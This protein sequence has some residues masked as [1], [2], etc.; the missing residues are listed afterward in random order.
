[1]ANK[2]GK[3]YIYL[4]WKDP[5]SREQILIGQLSKNGQYEFQYDFDIEK[6]LKKGFELLIAFDDINHKYTSDRLFPTFSSRIPDRRR[7]DI[8]LILNRYGLEQY[9]EYELLKKSGGRLPIDDL[10]FIDPILEDKEN[11]IIR[12]FYLAGPR[13]Y[14][15]CDSNDCSRSLNLSNEEELTLQCQPDNMYDKYAIKVL[16]KTKE[17]IGYI[18]RYYNKELI[19]LIEDGYNYTLKVSEYNRENNCNECLRVCLELKL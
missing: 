14:L 15:G 2:N 17:L 18:P 7:K 3:D 5:K 6:A 9:D 1:M 8:A 10:E 12:Y 19:K 11:P 13:H 16:S 4:V